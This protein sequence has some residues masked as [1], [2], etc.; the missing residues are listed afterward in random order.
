MS[1]I[2]L[3]LQSIAFFLLFSYMNHL[4]DFKIKHISTISLNLSC[5]KVQTE[6]SVTECCTVHIRYETQVTCYEL[7]Y[8]TV[9]PVPECWMRYETQVTCY[10][11]QHVTVSPVPECCMRRRWGVGLSVLTEWWAGPALLLKI[12]SNSDFKILHFFLWRSSSGHWT[13][14]SPWFEF[15]RKTW[16]CLLDFLVSPPQIT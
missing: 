5:Y 8:V 1:T 16:N 15:W 14:F 11:L 6:S 3:A 4:F 12:F 9:S 10:D 13:F 7:Q 2:H